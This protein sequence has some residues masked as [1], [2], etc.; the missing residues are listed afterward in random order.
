VIHGY[1]AASLSNYFSAAI[2]SQPLEGTMAFGTSRELR[3]GVIIT[4]A[5]LAFSGA[6]FGEG[7]RIETKVFVGKEDPKQQ[8]VSET[9]TLF[10]DGIVYDFLKKPQQV[11]VFRKPIG[12]KPGQFTLLN[13]Q[14]QIQTK[15]STDQ[16]AGAMSKL[17][18][19]AAAK[20][21]P[22][23]QFAANP[24]FDE[25]FDDVTGKLELV[26]HL[27]SY[28][29]MT[30]PAEHYEATVEYKEFLDWYTQLNTLLSGGGVPPEPRLRLNS[31][32]AR[33]KVVPEK[34][35]LTRAGENPLRAEHEFKW[36]I[37]QEDHKKID[38]VRESLTRYREVS[39]EEFLQ[40]TKPKV[41]K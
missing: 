8:A 3:V 10:L 12:G 20:K 29:V 27:E 19:W 18:T 17:K 36:R 24:E 6:T 7:F 21:D 35:E 34:V 23:L 14:Q 5:L 39:N 28:K 22:F 30:T 25:T 40:R 32:L 31:V 38:D 9:T 1:P 26:S 13:D 15:V 16:V 2:C 4:I 41:A 11:A 33:R 37:S